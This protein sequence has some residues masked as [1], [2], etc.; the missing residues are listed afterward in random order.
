MAYTLRRVAAGVK[1]PPA[2][3]EA[4]PDI[5]ATSVYRRV[6]GARFAEL[7]PLLQR[8]FGEIPPGSVGVGRGTYDVAGS[9]IRVLRPV[10][11]WFAWRRILFPEYARDV[12]FTVRNAPA[13]SGTLI[14]R[15][16]FSFPPRVR[17]M[18]DAMAVVGGTIVDRLGRRG[19]L[20]VELHPEVRDGGLRMTSG[21]LHLHLGRLR[22]P[23]PRIAEVTLDER[24]DPAA[25]DHQR[26]DVRITAP[27]IGEVFRYAGSFTYGF[28]DASRTRG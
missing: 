3:A 19:G 23:V 21:R 13:A 4:V 7:D 24:R 22:I 16:E 8:Y 12:P 27:W 17:V 25:I 10:F 6:L 2:Y 15:R 5:T 9:R 14:A 11:A 18:E 28:E 20:E 26:V 1:G